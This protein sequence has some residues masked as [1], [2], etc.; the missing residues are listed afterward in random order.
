MNKGHPIPFLLPF[1]RSLLLCR[2]PRH[3]IYPGDTPLDPE[4]MPSRKKVVN[5]SSQL[6]EEQGIHVSLSTILASFGNGSLLTRIDEDG[7]QAANQL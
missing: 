4:L 2:H 1:L 7:E 6:A 5:I 3:P